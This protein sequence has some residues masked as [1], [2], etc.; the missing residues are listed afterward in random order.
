MTVSC[1][2]GVGEVRDCVE[3]I[4]GVDMITGEKL[5]VLERLIAAVCLFI[6]V[7][8]ASFV[9]E[10]GQGVVKFI[11]KHWD[12]AMQFAS[13]YIDEGVTLL[14]KHGGDFLMNIAKK[15]DDISTVLKRAFNFGNEI[16]LAGVGTLKVEPE[17]ST[18]IQDFVSKIVSK[19]NNASSGTV[20]GVTQVERLIPGTPGI[21]TGG[22]STKLGKNLFE[23][24]GI[25]TNTKRTPY[26]AMHI[27]PKEFKNHPIIKKIGMNFDDASNGIF[28]KNRKVGGISPMS[29]HEGNHKAF[30]DFIESKL[31]C[32]DINKTVSELENE[33]YNIQQKVKKLMEDGLPMYAKEN[34]RIDNLG[35]IIREIRGQNYGDYTVDLWERWFNK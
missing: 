10:S 15:C 8:G 30:N 6:P 1:L 35:D 11:G 28:L 9:R 12:E 20:K 33:L 3:A 19:V 5:S 14:L 23:S 31:D 17:A 32:M 25:N 22:S 27:I 18:K 13:K 4:T 29:R 24:M 2:P 26:Q 16:E 7:V 34:E 21:V